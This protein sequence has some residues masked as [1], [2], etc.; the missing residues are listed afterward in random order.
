MSRRSHATLR[1]TE[2]SRQAAHNAYVTD[3][4]AKTRLT[5]MLN[6]HAK[7]SY[8]IP[9]VIARL[10]LGD[11]LDR[12]KTERLLAAMPPPLDLGEGPP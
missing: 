12:L 1:S 6:E 11:A 2:A 7:K 4:E 5:T 9:D 3:M 10:D 8:A